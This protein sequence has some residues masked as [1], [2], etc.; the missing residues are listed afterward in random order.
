MANKK[1]KFVE[2]EASER[3]AEVMTDAPIEIKLGGKKTSYKSIKTV[4]KI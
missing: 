1:G 2:P 4:F 3:V